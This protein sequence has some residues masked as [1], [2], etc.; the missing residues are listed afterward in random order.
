MV[1]EHLKG[2]RL[3]RRVL[4]RR[5]W[6]SPEELEQELSQLPDLAANVAP[7]EAEPGQAQA[8]EPRDG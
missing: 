4:R 2:L 1:H 6:I 5:G 7:A 3:D 8:E